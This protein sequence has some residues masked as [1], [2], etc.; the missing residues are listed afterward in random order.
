MDGDAHIKNMLRVRLDCIILIYGC[1]I[2]PL[3]DSIRIIIFLSIICA[4]SKSTDKKKLIRW[5]RLGKV[6]LSAENNADKNC[7]HTLRWWYWIWTYKRQSAMK[8]FGYLKIFGKYLLIPKQA[9][10]LEI[11]KLCKNRLKQSS[12]V[13]VLRVSIMGGDCLQKV[14]C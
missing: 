6:A 7:A 11:V 12:S 1:L 8:P 14:N 2:A 3:N 10:K 4:I 5:K 13:T 9:A